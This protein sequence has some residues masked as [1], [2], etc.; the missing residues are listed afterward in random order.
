MDSPVSPSQ[1][2]VR[3]L[4]GQGKELLEK[5]IYYRDVAGRIDAEYINSTEK[6]IPL[7]D[8]PYGEEI[9]TIKDLLPEVQEAIHTLE[10]IL[11]GNLS[12]E[13]VSECFENAEE[14]IENAQDT[15][16]ELR[17]LPDS[18]DED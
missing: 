9:L 11:E 14:S 1:E 5:L 10:K 2:D 4:L 18:E 7:D 8:L 17:R 16:D 12:P 3:A 13:K 6:N 15:L